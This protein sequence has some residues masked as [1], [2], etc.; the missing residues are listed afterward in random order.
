MN[1]TVAPVGIDPV[2]ARKS[3]APDPPHLDLSFRRHPTLG[4]WLDR[5][6]YRWPYTLSRGFRAP[7]GS[8]ALILQTVSG[9]IQADDHLTQRIQ[10]GPGAAVHIATQGAMPVYRAPAAM[11]AR[12]DVILEVEDHGRITYRPDLRI[13]FPEASLSQRISVR[14]TAS[15]TAIIADGFV[16]HD[17]DG[18][19]RP[20]HNYRS[21]LLVQRADGRLL[22]L[23]RTALAAPPRGL[24]RR[25]VYAAFGTL[26]IAAPRRAAW[27]EALGADIDGRMRQIQGVYA[28]VSA[29]PNGAG[30]ALRVAAL[31]GRHL[32]LG[33]RAGECAARRHLFAPPHAGYMTQPT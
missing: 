29:L 5:R 28:A 31:D 7:D 11:M 15:A 22:A 12:D 10:V 2:G 9:A 17:P 16:M 18:I 24:G 33:L 21:E 26:V 25:A 14:L 30:A 3:T 27:V 32:R 4:T 19:D 20:F 1:V 23:D 13:L 6:L 8:L